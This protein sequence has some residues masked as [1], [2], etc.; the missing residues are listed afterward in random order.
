M[1][2]IPVVLSGEGLSVKK[3]RGGNAAVPVEFLTLGKPK[4][5]AETYRTRLAGIKFELAHCVIFTGRKVDTAR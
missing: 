5:S 2:E 1:R 3:D 4:I